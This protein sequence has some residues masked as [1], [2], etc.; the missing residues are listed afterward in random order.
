[1]PVSLK[2][3]EWIVTFEEE[4]AERLIHPLWW[5]QSPCV[6]TVEAR[7]ACSYHLPRRRLDGKLSG[8]VRVVGATEFCVGV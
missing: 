5:E 7:G 1:M 3:L 6:R 2:W 4:A 8:S